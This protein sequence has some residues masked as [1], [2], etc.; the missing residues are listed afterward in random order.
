MVKK[1]GGLPSKLLFLFDC[2]EFDS[3][4]ALLALA[5]QGQASQGLPGHRL[6]SCRLCILNL[7][8]PTC[9][10]VGQGPSTQGPEQLRKLGQ[11][12]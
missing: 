3:A 12:S 10:I 8:V 11:V 1:N 6:G 4:K 9:A 5:Q 7:G 2:G